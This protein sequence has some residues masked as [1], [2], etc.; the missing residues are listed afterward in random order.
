M[1]EQQ[2]EEQPKNQIEEAKQIKTFDV[3]SEFLYKMRSYEEQKAYVLKWV[4]IAFECLYEHKQQLK[5]A[6][7]RIN[8]NGL[9]M[10]SYVWKEKDERENL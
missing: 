6:I 3:Q 10:T 1:D 4:E 2:T 5:T 8:E 9:I 7:I